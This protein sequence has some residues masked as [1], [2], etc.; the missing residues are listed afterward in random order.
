MLIS[1]GF[2]DDLFP[3]DE[4]IRFYNRTRTEYPSAD[5]SL[6]FASLGH[7]RGQNK[8]ARLA[9]RSAQE[10]AWFDYYVRGIGSVPFQ[11]VDDVHADVPDR[12]ALRA[13]RSG[14]GLGA[15][16][17]GRDPVRLGPPQ[18]DPA[19]GGLARRSRRR[20]TRSP[21]AGALRH[22]LGDR[23]GRHRDLP[24]STRC[25]TGGFTL[26]GSPTVVADITSPGS[27]SQI[28]ARLLDVDPA[29]TRRR[30]SRAACGGRRSAPTRCGRCSSCTRTATGSPTAT[31]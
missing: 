2:T 6:F 22:H 17:A 5:I 20:S 16:R 18:D 7:Q 19:D 26:M 21:A 10:L 28:A 14:R 24:A 13:A 3:A 4:A 1:S 30:W 27:N 31:W 23:P 9:A 29:P 15:A 12:G 25:P 8:A 11:G